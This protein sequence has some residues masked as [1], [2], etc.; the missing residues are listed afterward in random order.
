[1]QTNN[2]HSSSSNLVVFVFCALALAAVGFLIYNSMQQPTRMV[3]NTEHF[4]DS[5]GPADG[6]QVNSGMDT[7]YQ[8]E[9]QNPDGSEPIGFNEQP[10]AVVMIY[11]YGIL[12]NEQGERFLDEGAGT[13]DETYES[14]ARKVWSEQNNL[15]YTICDSS[16]VRIAN[17]E[18]AV[19]T[20]KPA[21]TASS[22]EE[23]AVALNVPV[24]TLK[25]TIEDYNAAANNGEFVPSVP[26]GLETTG[27]TIKKS[28]WAR[29]LV[30][31][32]YLA[33][34]MSCSIVFTFGGIGTDLDGR[35][36]NADNR[37]IPGLFAAGECTGLYHFKYPGATSVLRGL[38][39]GKTAGSEAAKYA[40]ALTK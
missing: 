10:E 4:T 33:Y 39:Y 11:P 20:D 36:I 23:L 31:M 17:Y 28:N 35:V 5:A 27:L 9:T 32:P 25:K 30:E 6:V 3:M 38:V 29:P 34:P 7:P 37:V 2:S 21:I 12:V 13:V 22:I 26:D 16:V 1:M 40:A 24:A 14:V 19:V 15:A 8:Q 18:H